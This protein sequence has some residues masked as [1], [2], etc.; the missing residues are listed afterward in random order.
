MEAVDNT[1]RLSEVVTAV[2]NLER[3]LGENFILV[4]GASLVCQGSERVTSDVDLLLPGASIPRLAH[5]LTQSPEVVRR[6]GVIYSTAGGSE[7]PV[8][9]LETLGIK[10][11]CCFLHNDETP[12]G[13]Q[14]QASDLVDITFI[15]DKM[16][17]PGKVVDDEVAKAILI[18]CFNMQLVKDRLKEMG[19][20]AL[21][22][23]VGGDKFQVP[24]EEDSEEQ[25]EYYLELIA[26]EAEPAGQQGV[27]EE[28]FCKGN[29]Y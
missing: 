6:A 20:L 4:G 12:G 7:F 19:S 23:S 18:G 22:L 21:F 26:D 17:L 8:D 5:S 15:C 16:K 27:T 10:I 2:V 1:Q 11:R 29:F 28:A 3:S 24:W 14:K 25:H 9:I 13:I